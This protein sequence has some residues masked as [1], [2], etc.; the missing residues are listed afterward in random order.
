MDSPAGLPLGD[1]SG[2]SFGQAGDGE[3][4]RRTEKELAEDS[5]TRLADSYTQW[6]VSLRPSLQS[7]VV[8]EIFIMNRLSV[9]CCASVISASH[10][11]PGPQLCLPFTSLGVVEVPSN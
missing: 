4:K 10:K 3:G 1:N 9:R 11:R 6:C 2:I 8:F 7:K 5:G